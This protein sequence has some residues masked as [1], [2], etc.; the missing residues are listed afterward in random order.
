MILESSATGLIN[1]VTFTRRSENNKRLSMTL[2]TDYPK[3]IYAQTKDFYK[4][5]IF[6]LKNI[7]IY[8]FQYLL[9]SI[10]YM[11]LLIV[12]LASF[13]QVFNVLEKVIIK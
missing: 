12:V 6:N 13:F 2:L 11:S 7:L 1:N 9:A 3:T 5:E 10:S 8:N 4:K